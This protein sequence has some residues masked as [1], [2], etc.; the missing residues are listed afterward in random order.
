MARSFSTTPRLPTCRFFRALNARENARSA[1]V[2]LIDARRERN[3]ELLPDVVADIEDGIEVVKESDL[4]PDAVA[5]FKDASGLIAEAAKR[6]EA[7]GEA[8]RILKHIPSLIAVE[9]EDRGRQL[10]WRHCAGAA[11]PGPNMAKSREPWQ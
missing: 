4:A 10:T 2:R 7:L 5:A 8:Q 3:S 11:M 1:L 6:P 9:N